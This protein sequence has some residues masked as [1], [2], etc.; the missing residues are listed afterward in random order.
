MAIHLQHELDLACKTVQ[1]CAVLTD[2][3]QKESLGSNTTIKKWDYSPVT[4]CDFAV[5]ALLTFV[6]NGAFQDDSFLAEESADELRRDEVLLDQVWGLIRSVDPDFARAGFSTPSSREQV[7]DM[8]DYGGKNQKSDG[9]RTWVFDPIDGTA[10]FLRGQQYAINCAFLVN[11]IEQ[12]GVIGCPNV[13]TDATTVHEDE[14]D[15]DRLG[16]MVFAVRGGGTWQRPMQ[17]GNELVTARRIERFVSDDATITEL[18]WT[19]CSTYTSTIVHLQQR[20]AAQLQTPWPGVDLYS[21]LMKYAALGLARA[22]VC[23]RIFKYGSWKSN[24]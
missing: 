18:T 19:D 24:M 8:I 21:S 15:T 1:L 20:V 14:V 17:H 9:R 2:R 11:G 22:D 3:V 10:T 5:Q 16:T 13:K 4:I 12:I 7:L 6:I 23:M